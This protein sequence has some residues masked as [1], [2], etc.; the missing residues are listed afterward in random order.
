MEPAPGAYAL[1]LQRFCETHSLYQPLSL[2]LRGS[3]LVGLVLAVSPGTS[4]PCASSASPVVKPLPSE[5]RV[6]AGEEALLPCEASGVPRPSVT[7]QKEGLSLPT[8]ES[9]SSK[10]RKTSSPGPRTPLP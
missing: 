8:G 5:V 3:L 6:V 1:L 9:R 7:W 10:G 2:V 4:V